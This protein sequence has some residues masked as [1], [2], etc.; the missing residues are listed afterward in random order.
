VASLAVFAASERF[1][2][3]VPTEIDPDHAPETVLL[4]EFAGRLAAA[5]APPRS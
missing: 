5:L 3:L 4:H 1:A 2:G